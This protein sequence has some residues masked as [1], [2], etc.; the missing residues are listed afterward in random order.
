M[1]SKDGIEPPIR[2]FSM[3]CYTYSVAS[4]IQAAA[5]TLSECLAN[6]LTK[7]VSCGS[8]H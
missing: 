2:G 8:I 6:T 3:Q 4:A 1:V 7:M 5:L